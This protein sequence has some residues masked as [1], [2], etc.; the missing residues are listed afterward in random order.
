MKFIVVGT[1]A[2]DVSGITPIAQAFGANWE[3][4]NV[5]H[6]RDPRWGAVFGSGAAATRLINQCVTAYHGQTLGA[7]VRELRAQY[8]QHSRFTGL[9]NLGPTGTARLLAA[10]GEVT[11]E[12][13]DPPQWGLATALHALA[14]A[15]S[16]G[17][18]P[19]HVVTLRELLVQAEQLVAG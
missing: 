18:T 1:V 16:Q 8:T 4:I 14:N 7:A 6:L 11:F 3:T 13:P 17:V 9:R 19:Q 5:P 12:T 2:W 15:I 10:L